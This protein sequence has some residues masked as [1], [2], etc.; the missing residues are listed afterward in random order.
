MSQEDFVVDFGDGNAVLYPAFASGY[1]NEDE[2]F[3]YPGGA[4]TIE[5]YKLIKSNKVTICFNLPEGASINEIVVLG[6]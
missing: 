3:V 1:I 5:F 6:C 4:I 2:S